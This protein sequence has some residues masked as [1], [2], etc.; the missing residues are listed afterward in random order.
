MNIEKLQS[1]LNS[2][3]AKPRFVGVTYTSKS[4]GEKAR[5]TM[6]I[7]A[8]Y[9]ETLKKSI[10]EL[11]TRANELETLSK[12]WG[13]P[14][15]AV[16]K[17]YIDT[18]ASWDKSLQA[19]EAGEQNEN[20]TKKDMYNFIAPGLK[21]NKNDNRLEISGLVQAKK[22]LEEGRESIKKSSDLVKAKLKLAEL[23]PMGK[24]RSLSVAP[25][26]MESVR[27]NGESLEF[28]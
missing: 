23:C 18:L 1:I 16:E 5:Y 15:E 6:I 14:F 13:L 19:Q 12:E 25:E 2:L 20:Y 22:I 27:A 21:V 7:G 26:N 4:K 24:Y 3:A 9:I 8:S 17:A 28:D 11:E 10:L